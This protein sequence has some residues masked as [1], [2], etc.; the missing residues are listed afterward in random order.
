MKLSMNRCVRS[1]RHTPGALLLAAVLLWP[2]PASAAPAAAPAPAPA[3]PAKPAPKADPNAPKPTSGANLTSKQI[4]NAVARAVAALY[5]S[6][7]TYTFPPEYLYSYA[8]NQET[9]N[10][11]GNHALACWALLEAGESYQN[12]PLYRRINWVFSSDSPYTYDRGMRATMLAHLPRARWAPW[13]R[14]DGQWLMGALS[15]KG[16]FGPQWAGTPTTGVGDNANGQYGVLGLWH[17]DTAGYP[18]SEDTWKK[19]D[20]Y[21]RTAQNKTEGDLPAGWGVY[22]MDTVDKTKQ[23]EFYTR[24]SGPMTGGAIAALCLT[25]RYLYG[26]QMVDPNKPNV[27]AN[28]RKGIRWLDENFS[29]DDKAEESDWFY[30]MWCMQRV[31]GAT[32]YRSFNNVDWFRDVT[33]R[34]IDRQLADGTWQGTQGRLLSTGFAL[35]YLSRASDPLAISKVRFKS[36]DKDG[37]LEEGAWNNRPHDIWNFVDYASEQYEVGTTWQIAELSQPVYELI[38]SPILYLSTNKAFKL[39]ETEIDNLR[40][41]LNAGGLLI[42]NADDNPGAVLHSVNELV[43]KLYPGK[44]LDKVPKEHPFY[45]VHQRLPLGV[46]MMSVDN[47]IRPLILHFNRDL[48]GD[49]QRKDLAHGEGFSALSN[50]YLYVTGM[51]PRRT[52]LS[53]NHVVQRVENPA[54]PVAAAR[55]KFS[56]R[57]DPEPGALSQLKAILANNHNIDLQV[58]E[59]APGELGKTRVAFLSVMGDAR[60]TDTEAGSIRRWVEEGG[61]LWIDPAGGSR[62]ALTN[63]EAILAQIAPGSSLVPLSSSSPIISGNKMGGGF[64]NHRVTYRWYALRTMGPR[65]TPRL[66]SVELNGRPGI[67]YSSEDITCGLAGLDDWGIFGYTPQSAR[68]LVINNI[69]DIA[70]HPVRVEAPATAPAPEATPSATPATPATAPDAKP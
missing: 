24:E 68:Q 12:P 70:L 67:I 28:L 65:Y 57:F 4:E 59:L 23:L 5:R 66:Q 56:G 27:S 31:G 51:N 14:R 13:V 16:N 10:M 36:L 34:V 7:P 17:I 21:W 47:G 22:S 1:G 8:Y 43:D 35:L 26:P 50:I 69:L 41:Y 2:A 25:E 15:D 11:M 61:T 37:R 60:M 39:R 38:E 29:L 62:A 52:R 42:T 48:S 18:I 54:R 9:R 58:S 46:Q 19:V 3:A 40:S 32:G 63:A 30:Y 64:D 49:L 33:A 53:S 44:K 55:V 20:N 6:E 45:D